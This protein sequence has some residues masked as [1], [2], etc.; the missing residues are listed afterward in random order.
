MD[1][2][3]ALVPHTIRDNTASAFAKVSA[4]MDEIDL[5]QLLIYIVDR[6]PAEVLPYLAEQFHVLGYEGWNY[7]NTD[8]KKRALLKEALPL[9]RYKGTV[10]AVERALTLLGLPAR[11][12]QWFEYGGDPHHFRVDVDITGEGA[13]A[14]IARLDRD[15]TGLVMAWKRKSSVFE[16][17]RLL[18]SIDGTIRIGGAVICGGTLTISPYVP[19]DVEIEGTMPAFAGAVFY[20]GTLTIYPG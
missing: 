18:L 11:L 19:S 8:P 3:L 10:W 6:A 5:T 16:A 14:D 17:L 2:D 9:H 12:W 4:R 13:S 7:A 15:A 1:N 20:S